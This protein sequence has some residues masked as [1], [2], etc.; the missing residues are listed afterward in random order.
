MAYLCHLKR[1]I[2]YRPPTKPL[3]FSPS[4]N[5]V[6]LFPS[7]HFIEFTH[8]EE[9]GY[10]SLFSRFYNIRQ[11]CI[12]NFESGILYSADMG[13][14]FSKW[15]DVEMLTFYNWYVPDYGTHG[16]PVQDFAI[17]L[18]WTKLRQITIY[19]EL[20]SHGVILCVRPR[21]QIPIPFR[22][23]PNPSQ[24][25]SLKKFMIM[26]PLRPVGGELYLK[27]YQEYAAPLSDKQKA[28]IELGLVETIN[29]MWP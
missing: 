8:D 22:Y 15:K 21:H 11:V 27:K 1:L 6:D 24:F 3:V 9:S 10:V 17:S 23:I 7:L 19:P 14:V 12:A 20:A 4:L 16:R 25:P 18:A 5:S 2:L 26:I 13:S 28:L 29:S